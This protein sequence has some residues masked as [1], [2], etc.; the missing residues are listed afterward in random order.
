ME[1]LS[2]LSLASA[3]IQ[4]V[5]FS[6]KV[7]ARTREAYLSADGTTQETVHLED[8]IANLDELMVGIN[9]SI[10]WRHGT[11]AISERSPDHQLL[12][13]AEESH[14]IAVDL[15]MVLDKVR[16]DQ[17]GGRRNPLDQGFRS[18]LEQNNI[19]ALKN[20]LDEIRKQVDT[21]LLVSIRYLC[22]VPSALVRVL[23]L[24]VAKI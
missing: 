6:S 15:R 9:P 18:V 16:L 2:A 21:T 8:A 14:R 4:I 13:F 7:I 22:L 3:V 24:C 17:N 19:S 10:S 20:R 1:P 12:Q 11:G 23:I 5:D